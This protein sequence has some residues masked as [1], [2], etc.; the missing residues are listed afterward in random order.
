MSESRRSDD[1]RAC[2]LLAAYEMDL[3]P[4]GERRRF[5]DHLAACEDCLEELY[6]MAPLTRQLKTAPAAYADRIAR[7]LA[8]TRPSPWR[9][10]RAAFAPGGRLGYLVPAILTAALA[11]AVLWPQPQTRSRWAGLADLEPL[12]WVHI[13]VRGGET[14]TARTLYADGM[15]AYGEG[16]YAVAAE[17]LADAAA[18]LP[19]GS[20]ERQQAVLYQG[21]AL[22]LDG[23][24]A[25]AIAP[26]QTATE[27]SLRPVADRG[28]WYL[29]QAYLLTGQVAPARGILDTLRG[30]PVYGDRAGDLLHALQP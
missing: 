4:D 14:D 6:A 8:A 27:A 3:L 25:G 16:R 5:E 22:L 30:S 26:L 17:Q 11:I 12:P 7:T 28:R 23:D 1:T 19:A 13:E 9:R 18:G 24:A 2:D 15:T 21:V 20:A 10:L 29:V